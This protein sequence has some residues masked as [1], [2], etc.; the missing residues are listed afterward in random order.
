VRGEVVLL[1]ITDIVLTEAGLAAAAEAQR[2]ERK[3]RG[4][5]DY[6]VQRQVARAHDG[7]RA[8]VR[9]GHYV[10]AVR[11]G[12]GFLAM[13]ELQQGQRARIHRLLLEAYVALRAY[14]LAAESCAL[15]RE[16]APDAK[17]DP[18]LL[19]PKILAACEVLP[20]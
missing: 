9:H 16:A 13:G 5:S 1:P 2:L 20:Q 14:G 6:R 18:K 12:A 19:S 7:L 11:R 3:Q 4:G 8:D 17:L 15:W 10:E